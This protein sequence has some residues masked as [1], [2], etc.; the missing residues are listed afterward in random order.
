MKSKCELNIPARAV[1][2]QH[3]QTYMCKDSTLQQYTC[4]VQTK[5]QGDM[6]I[7]Q[8]QHIHSVQYHQGERDRDQHLEAA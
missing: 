1:H 6:H 4:N 8:A 5:E 3:L 2:E 7:P